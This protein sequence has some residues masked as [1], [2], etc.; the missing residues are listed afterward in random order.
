MTKDI[1]FDATYPHNLRLLPPVIELNDNIK[2]WLLKARVQLAELKGYS[3]A[4]PN[5]MLLLSPAILKEAV[6]SSEIENINTTIEK[7]LQQQLFPEVEQ[8]GENKEVLRYKE[9]VIH[10]YHKM[11]D[12]SIS[13]RLINEIHKILLGDRS[14]GFRKFQNHIENSETKKIIYTPPPSTQIEKLIA[15]WEKYIHFDGHNNDDADCSDPL[16]KCAI[17]HYQFEAIHPFNDGNGRTGR[18]LMVLYLIYSQVLQY[19]ILFISGY[20]NKHRSEYY[21]LLQ[22]VTTKN[23][24]LPFIEYMLTAFC[25]QAL[26]TKDQLF[27]LMRTYYDRKQK[28]KEECKSIYS[29]DLVEIIFSTPIITPIKLGTLLGVHYTTATRYL[30]ELT[31]KQFLDHKKVGKYQLYINSQL[32]SILEGHHKK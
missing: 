17:S 21:R 10:G 12:I 7:V 29:S 15:D 22:N 19:P 27:Q 11:K 5:P 14:Y 1:S 28:I 3:E 31:S 13:S 23:E 30:K 6:A 25:F 18:I 8:K 9:A 20:I 32:I 24:W 16:I 26:E 4:L 2:S